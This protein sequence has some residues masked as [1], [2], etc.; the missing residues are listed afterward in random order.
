M[1]RSNSIPLDSIIR[2]VILSVNSNYFYNIVIESFMEIIDNLTQIVNHV[3]NFYGHYKPTH[4][5]KC[6]YS[7][8]PLHNL[9]FCA[10]LPYLLAAYT[11]A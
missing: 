4:L 8:S 11:K 5:N 1:E 3:Y 10:P 7:K 2:T 9:P 6:C